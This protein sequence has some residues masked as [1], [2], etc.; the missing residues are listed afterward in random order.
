MADYRQLFIFFMMVVFPYL[1]N[2]QDPIDSSATVPVDTT[3]TVA[4]IDT[5]SAATPAII[6]TS[7]TL[8][9]TATGDSSVAN[10][11][12][13]TKLKKKKIIKEGLNAFF[14][15]EEL[16]MNKGEIVSNVLP[17]LITVMIRFDLLLIWHFQP[18]GNH[19]SSQKKFMK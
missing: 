19:C 10:T 7:S 8:N 5:S 4:P 14:R 16:E 1:A 15:I 6:D 18:L 13:S 2:A 12:D 17:F 11:V 3:S 9:P